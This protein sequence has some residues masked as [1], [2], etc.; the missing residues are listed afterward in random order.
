M[1]T[2]SPLSFERTQSVAV[3]GGG[4]GGYEAALAAAQQGA[5]VTL[6]ERAGVGG[7]AVITDV[8]PSK[9]LI[10]TADAAVAIAGASDLGVQLFA[11]SDSGTPLKPE[12]AINLAA[13][14]RRLLS[15]A[16][17][18]SDDMRAQLVEAGVRI[19]SGHGRLDGT[20][21]LI[22]ATG[23]GGTDFD[24]VEADTLVVSVG[25]SPRE[26]PSAKP[27]GE[28]IL[29]WTQLYD[30]KSLPEHLIVVGSGV[31]GAEF[32]SA[33][34]NLGAKVTLISS[35]DQVLPGEDVDAAAVIEKVFK[36]GGMTVLSKSRAEKVERTENGVVAT[37]S[38]G[39]TVEGSHCLMAVGSIPNTAGIG[40]EEA[41][42]QLTDSG[43]IQ[44]N[45]VARTSVPNIYAAGDC[46]TFVP[47][48]SVA[49]M[50][51]RQAVFH[52]L[53][54]TVIPLERRRIT[55]NIFTAPEIATVGQ[56]QKDIESGLVNGYVHKLPLAANPRA[57]M[58]GVKDGFVK[59]IAREG[60]GTVI[61]GV[62]VAPRASEL[63]YP[64]AIAVERRLTVDQ[65]SRV[66]AVYP[67]L[68]GS[69]TDAARA[70]HLVQRD[71]DP[72]S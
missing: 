15:L 8:V 68:T 64:I 33:Y 45:R 30:M 5:E 69:I 42:V 52:A 18:Q 59:I 25:A 20:H 67:S 61:G 62:I 9:S 50:Q 36:R 39:R 14:N 54:D 37:L 56:Q 44:V 16:R 71:E 41:G 4:P 38:D 13:V 34:M 70:M 66:F 23:P 24:R 3:L 46:T 12:I 58:M 48:A 17:Q 10:A 2:M 63:I 40:L 6:V 49:A 26:L 60:S 47:L 32:A 43:H 57:K 51:G 31:T 55:A 19:I 7:S 35:R 28:R 53:G 22:A 11:R 29:T 72:L 27:D 21:A 65:V 1:E